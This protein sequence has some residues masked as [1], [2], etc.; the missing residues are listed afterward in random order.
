MTPR[1]RA[2]ALAYELDTIAHQAKE[3]WPGSG[4]DSVDAIEAAIVADRRELL[5]KDEAT[6][7]A[8]AKEAWTALYK[9]ERQPLG[10]VDEVRAVIDVLRR[11]RGVETATSNGDRS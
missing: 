10:F 6:I 7:K 2:E 11:L 4:H 1:E 3:E 5:A 9:S 8:I